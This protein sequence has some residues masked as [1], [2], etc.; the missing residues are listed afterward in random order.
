MKYKKL[1]GG[2]M[3]KI[4]NQST[5]SILKKLG[6]SASGVEDIVRYVDE[7]E[8]IEGAPHIKDEHLP[9]FDCAFPPQK[10]QAHHPLHGA[11]QD[12]GGGAAVPLGAISKTVNMPTDA[13]PEERRER[14]PGGLA[15]RPQGHRGLP[16]RL[17]AQPA[18]EP[19][20]D[21]KDAAVAAPH[22]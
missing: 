5:P 14:L 9:V 17:Q 20:K 6:Y 3:M 15:P 19:S 18:S 22:G 11:H 8:T 4:V 10:R 12:D 1:V 2:G 16:R 13:T 7:R 21:T